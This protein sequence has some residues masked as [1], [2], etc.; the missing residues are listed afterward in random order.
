M[1]S[2]ELTARPAGP[3]AATQEQRPWLM[4]AV[5]L[6]GQFMGLLDVTIVNVAT[7]AIGAGLHSS[8]AALQMVVGGYTVAYAML[9]ITGARLGDLYGRR[10]MY[11][12]GAC[13]FTLTSLL[14]GLAP[15]TAVLVGARLVQGAGAAVMVPQIMSVIQMRF[16]GPARAKA[17][18]AYGAV[19]SVGAVA[20]LVLGGFLVG[21][22][23][24]GTAWRPVF[25][26][27]VP[28]GALL[29][30][31]VPRLV[32]A[33]EPRGTRRLD[34]A[35][36]ALAVPAVILVVL[37]LVLGHETGWPAWTYACM[38]AGA[39]LATVFVLVE[40]RV[41]DRGGDP[42]LD[43][44]VLRAPGLAAGIATLGCMQVA[45]GGFLF[46]L[47]LHLQLGLGD[48]ALRAG[49]AFFPL[50]AVFGVV[51]FF[52][53]KLPS[54]VHHLLPAAGLA[55]CA[56]GYLGIAAGLHDG[57]QDSPLLWAAM[58]LA[59]VGMG[60]SLSPLL[61]LA[62]VGVRPEQA[63]DA[64][65]LLTTT[66]QLGQVVGV[67][68]FGTVFLSLA[69]SHPSGHAIATTSEWMAALSVVGVAG[70]ASLAR[71]V[72]GAR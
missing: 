23:L 53:R 46:T 44:A 68:A 24:L 30:A 54:R 40:R 62:L 18:S 19:L 45:Y 6:L 12:V 51:G 55:L 66:M 69:G 29:V 39:V 9:L 31:L 27:N 63:P 5:L 13:V 26:V 67:A 2:P 16:T 22:D 34:F 17:L 61:A 60:L 70:G 32:P 52:W 14:C 42:L 64:G 15:D 49:L 7:P 41:A 36:L 10:R 58:V 11:L 57:S 8:G 48:S 33:D 71:T 38:A 56:L 3:A 28:L 4:L 25:L 35:G 43:L 50:A 37:P 21:A 47:A 20:G 65:G 1:A 72:R 59:G